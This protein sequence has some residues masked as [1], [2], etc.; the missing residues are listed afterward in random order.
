MIDLFG[1]GGLF[2]RNLHKNQAQ[3]SL[4]NTYTFFKLKYS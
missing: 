2:W 3:R 1:F 4:G